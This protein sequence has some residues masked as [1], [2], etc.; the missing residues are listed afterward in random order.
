MAYGSSIAIVLFKL[1][2]CRLYSE[3]CLQSSRAWIG[4]QT[5]VNGLSKPLPL[6]LHACLCSHAGVERNE[7]IM[8]WTDLAAMSYHTDS[9]KKKKKPYSGK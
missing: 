4:G 7:N 1:G 6:A 3:Y 2:P 8:A 5:P 9:K